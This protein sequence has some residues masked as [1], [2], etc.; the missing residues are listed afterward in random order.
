MVGYQGKGLNR[1]VVFKGG[2][3]HVFD[4]FLPDFAVI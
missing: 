3:S 1:D 4:H 2:F